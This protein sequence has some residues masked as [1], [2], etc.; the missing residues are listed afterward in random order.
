MWAKQQLQETIRDQMADYLLVIVSNRQPY[1]HILKSGKI[2]CQR[3]PG[4]LVTA[5]DPVMQAA[6]GIWIA[7]G[8][9]PYDRAILDENNKVMIPAGN[10]FYGLRRIFLS[11][12]DM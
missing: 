6:R 9:S 5:L 1:S 8:T 3:Q 10:S 12:D 4:G 2:I 7:S 11:K